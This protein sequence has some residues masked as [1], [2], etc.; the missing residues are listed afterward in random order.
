M[1]P[2]DTTAIAQD[3]LK[4]FLPD[5]WISK[6]SNR[7]HNNNRITKQQAKISDSRGPAY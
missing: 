4:T 7:K 6:D 3:L 1:R 5:N 2:S